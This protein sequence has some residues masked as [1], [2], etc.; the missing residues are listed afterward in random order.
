MGIDGL[1]CSVGERDVLISLVVRKECI[2][3][4]CCWGGMHWIVQCVAR[5]VLKWSLFGEGCNSTWV[6]ER[7]IELFRGWVGCTNCSVGRNVPK[8]SVFGTGCT[9]MFS[10]WEG[11]TELFSG[12]GKL[13]T[14]YWKG[15]NEQFSEWEVMYLTL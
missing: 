9:G 2:G 6:G 3:T 4:F 14:V 8:S 1:Y 12:L 11:C 15:C 10:S 13:L 7:C 5:G